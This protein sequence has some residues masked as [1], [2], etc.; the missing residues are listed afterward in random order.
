MK[1]FGTFIYFSRAVYMGFLSL[2]CQCEFYLPKNCSFRNIKSQSGIKCLDNEF[3]CKI[4]YFDF[5][6]KLNWARIKVQKSR[7]FHVNTYQ[8]RAQTIDRVSQF[9]GVAMAVPDQ[10]FLSNWLLSISRMLDKSLLIECVI[11]LRSHIASLML[12]MEMVMT[13]YTHG[14]LQNQGIFS[15]R[16]CDLD[17]ENRKHIY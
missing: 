14:Y 5:L 7:I 12:M 11:Q 4:P 15:L 3:R 16:M 10:N 17:A 1:I 6:S 13:T 2:G 8:K 9:S